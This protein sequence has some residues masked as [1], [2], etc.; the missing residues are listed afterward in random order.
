M[1]TFELEPVGG[2]DVGAYEL[3]YGTF[4]GP[5]IAPFTV[6]AAVPQPAQVG[7]VDVTYSY[8]PSF[9]VPTPAGS[10]TTEI[11][12]AVATLKITPS[13]ELEPKARTA[14]GMTGRSGGHVLPAAI[15][16]RRI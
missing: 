3:Q 7:T 8:E 16:V 2:L 14:P 11:P 15:G 10:C 12:A 13:P 5:A 6:V 9:S 4:S 1:G